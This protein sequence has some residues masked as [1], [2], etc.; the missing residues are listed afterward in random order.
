MWK[1]VS[2]MCEEMS[3]RYIGNESGEETDEIWPSEK[4]M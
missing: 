3:K 2:R 4:T 1:K